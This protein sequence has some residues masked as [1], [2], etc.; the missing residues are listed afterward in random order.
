VPDHHTL[1]SPAV[2]KH[3]EP[4]SLPNDQG[5]AAVIAPIA[6]GGVD[7]NAP[8]AS[9]Y[10]AQPN[11]VVASVDAPSGQSLPKR[12]SWCVVTLSDHRSGLPIVS[13]LPRDP[14][15]PWPSGVTD[16]SY[17]EWGGLFNTA[18][19][20]SSDQST[21]NRV[22]ITDQAPPAESV[23]ESLVQS[24]RIKVDS[25]L[26]CS[27]TF[28]SF[29][30]ALAQCSFTSEEVVASRSDLLDGLWTVQHGASAHV[31]SVDRAELLVPPARSWSE[32]VRRA[33]HWRVSESCLRFLFDKARE[34]CRREDLYE[35]QVTALA[36]GLSGACRVMLDEGMLGFAAGYHE[37][38]PLRPLCALASSTLAWLIEPQLYPLPADGNC[39]PFPT[40]TGMMYA[41]ALHRRTDVLPGALA[42][43]CI[44][45][46]N[47]QDEA[48]CIDDMEVLSRAL[49]CACLSGHVDT[50]RMILDNCSAPV[51]V[52]A[53]SVA[54]A[55]L[56]PLTCA[57]LS[58]SL[59]MTAHVL[60]LWR[61]YFGERASLDF[62]TALTAAARTGRCKMIALLLDH[63]ANVNALDDL[64][65]VCFFWSSG[66]V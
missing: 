50:V 19:F 17:V 18:A 8:L 2:F 35:A 39:I 46:F 48:D 38:D 24:L 5:A 33:V 53:A 26:S 51:C 32:L 21:L 64:S 52:L 23:Q 60:Q 30:A 57:V 49:A 40:A 59:R 47:I 55:S 22:L 34:E 16:R 42:C 62:A 37:L 29:T 14:L 31:A 28:A 7:T 13:S 36:L 41:A 4:P 11:A 15:P 6:V 58:G 3:A 43:F 10:V 44:S 63:G 61:K 27:R 56:D 1:L 12:H 9:N 54:H 25:L 45:I 65:P 66:D 20:F